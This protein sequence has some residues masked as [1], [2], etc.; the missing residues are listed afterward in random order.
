MVMTS[1][2]LRGRVV[3]VFKNQSMIFEIS[4][5]VEDT[6]LP[7]SLSDAVFHAAS[8]GASLAFVSSVVMEIEGAD[9]V[10]ANLRARDRWSYIATPFS[11]YVWFFFLRSWCCKHIFDQPN[12][13]LGSKRP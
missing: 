12:R 9:A 6:A 11:S 8:N 10:L 3:S 1:G 13:F 2:L 5:A 4:S 7:S